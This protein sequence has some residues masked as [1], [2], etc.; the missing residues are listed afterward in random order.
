MEDASKG[1][2]VSDPGTEKFPNGEEPKDSKEVS[3]ECFTLR[4]LYLFAGAERKTSVIR[5]LEQLTKR[6]GWGLVA[7]EVDLKRGQEFD[8]TH[9]ELQDKIISDTVIPMMACFTV[10]FVHHLVVHGA[11]FAWLT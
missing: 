8:L 6:K 9:S 11:V 4:V 3:G 7:R 2:Q 10:S 5:Y 1:G